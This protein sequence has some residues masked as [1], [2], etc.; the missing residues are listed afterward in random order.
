[1]NEKPAEESPLLPKLE[2]VI[3]DLEMPSETDA[4]FRAF[5]L[6]IQE[7]EKEKLPEL[8]E[9]KHNEPIG[10]RELDEFFENAVEVEDWME[11]DE[12]AVAQRFADLRDLLKKEISEVAVYTFGEREMDVVIIGKVSEGFAGVVTLIVET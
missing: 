5:S 2:A 1:M 12:K 8:L 6:D 4:P 11:D 7:V 10:N 9:L 3:A